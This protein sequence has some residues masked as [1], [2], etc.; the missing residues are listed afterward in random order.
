MGIF[1]FCP[2][3]V[4]DQRL[5]LKC[6]YSHWCINCFQMP[7]WWVWRDGLSDD[8]MRY[9][10]RVEIIFFHFPFYMCLPATAGLFPTFWI[11]VLYSALKQVASLRK[12]D[13]QEQAR[14]GLWCEKGL[15]ALEHGKH[16]AV[17]RLFFP[18]CE[19]NESA[20]NVR[21]YGKGRSFYSIWFS[22]QVSSPHCHPHTHVLRSTKTCVCVWEAWPGWLLCDTELKGC[23]L[24]TPHYVFC[25]PFCWQ[26]RTRFWTGVLY[27][28]RVN[29]YYFSLKILL[30]SASINLRQGLLVFSL[31]FSV[32]IDTGCPPPSWGEGRAMV[33]VM[34]CDLVAILLSSHH[35]SSAHSFTRA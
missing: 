30:A 1:S 2:S 29:N 34:C 9:V 12:T 33:Q 21:R 22:K 14:G 20:L 31:L 11:L 17:R 18:L 15:I 19:Y 27:S 23:W 16:H 13:L 24:L 10:H 5:L 28:L 4:A 25:I 32:F 35:R 6:E 7:P 8:K 26:Q 3:S